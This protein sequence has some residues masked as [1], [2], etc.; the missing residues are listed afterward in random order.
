MQD[1]LLRRVAEVDMLHLDI[2]LELLVRRRVVRPVVMLPRPHA[3]VLLCLRDIAVLIDARVDEHD[4]A[5]VLLRLL[6]NE[7]EDTA[8]AR[9]AH[10]DERDL[11]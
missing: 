6:I 7:L 10:R 4:I 8:R 2:A 5:V 11:V 1:L 3:G 9:D